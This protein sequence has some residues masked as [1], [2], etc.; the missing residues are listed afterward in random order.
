MPAFDGY[1]R[2]IAV[3]SH[4][5]LS[6]KAGI[7]LFAGTYRTG[8]SL[9]VD[10]DV[11]ILPHIGLDTRR[12]ARDRQDRIQHIFPLRFPTCGKETGKGEQQNLW[13]SSWLVK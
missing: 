11:D 7:D 6:H 4:F 3:K 12:V 10:I 2:K 8:K 9:Y 5:G 1:L 13:L